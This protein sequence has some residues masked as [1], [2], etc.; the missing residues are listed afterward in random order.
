MEPKFK[1]WLRVRRTAIVTFWPSSAK[2]G[3]L[4]DISIAGLAFNHSPGKEQMMGSGSLSISVPYEGFHL[5]NLSF[6]TVSDEGHERL[7]SSDLDL[8][9]CEVAFVDLSAL[10]KPKLEYFMEN[11]T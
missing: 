6:Q 2:I 8:S 11:Y 7:S 5:K 9:R 4:I 10:Q 1:R 3:H